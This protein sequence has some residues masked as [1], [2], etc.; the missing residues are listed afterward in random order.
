MSVK[1]K[2]CEAH[3]QVACYESFGCNYDHWTCMLARTARTWYPK[4]RTSVAASI[5]AQTSFG[6]YKSRNAT[7]SVI[8]PSTDDISLIPF[9][10]QP[11]AHQT[12]SASHSGLFLHNGLTT[13]YSITV[14]ASGT[15]VRARLL[16]DRI[17]RARS[18]EE[19]RLVLKNLDK[20]SDLLCG[21]IDLAEL[22]RNS[23]PDRLWV[24][25]ANDAYDMLCEFMN[26]LNTH[27]GLYNVSSVRIASLIQ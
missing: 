26:E 15:L 5:R 18:R 16:T 10:D 12:R 9:F 2:L 14:L 13:P 8:P 21:V 25:S 3:W 6:V 7:T 11:N 23:H 19:L 22:I 4:T 1:L 24:K 20:L 27:V 17:L